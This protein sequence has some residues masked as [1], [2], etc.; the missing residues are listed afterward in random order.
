MRVQHSNPGLIVNET[1]YVFFKNTNSVMLNFDKRTIAMLWRS[2]AMLETQQNAMTMLPPMDTYVG[3]ENASSSSSMSGIRVI[4]QSQGGRTPASIVDTTNMSSPS[5]Q[6]IGTASRG[7]NTIPTPT[8][9]P[10]MMPFPISEN[11]FSV[12]TMKHMAHT[13][14]AVIVADIRPFSAFHAGDFSKE[15]INIKL[16]NISAFHKCQAF[17]TLR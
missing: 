9:S 14:P 3:G 17:T 8:T 2:Q 6:N 11:P 10:P 1:V 12:G 5:G 15:A 13:L 7:I 16:M 4:A